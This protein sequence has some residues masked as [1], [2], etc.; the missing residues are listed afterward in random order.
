MLAGEGNPEWVEL[1]DSG[2]QASHCLSSVT[3]A[4]L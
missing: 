4:K 1:D 2:Y 3:V